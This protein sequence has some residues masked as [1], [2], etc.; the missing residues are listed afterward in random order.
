MHD[1]F[2]NIGGLKGRR[3]FDK[4]KPVARVSASRAA[5]RGLVAEAEAPLPA[6][7]ASKRKA[8]RIP[9][10]LQ[11]Q[12]DGVWRRVAADVSAG[13]ALLLLAERLEVPTVTVLIELK[14]GSGKWEA[15][16]DILRRERRGDRVAHHTRF[17]KP[18]QVAGL[19]AVIDR[20]LAEGAE[21]LPTV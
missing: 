17:A 4:K 19:S 21:R 3:S 2:S 10:T 1:A 15:T 12:V 18:S 14:D 6:G 16:A 8:R 20:C 9:T 11:I 5:R 7:V 13:G